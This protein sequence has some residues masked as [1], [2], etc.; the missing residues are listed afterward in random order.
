MH[1]ETAAKD[2]KVDLNIQR[3]RF[4]SFI[5]PLEQLHAAEFKG[6]I[7]AVTDFSKKCLLDS[8]VKLFF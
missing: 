2:A 5:S 6:K 1:N 7:K 8:T 3:R 4:I